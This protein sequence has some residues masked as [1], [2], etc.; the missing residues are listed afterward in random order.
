MLF[1]SNDGWFGQSIG[2][3]QHL[4][5]ARLRAVEQGL[6][7]VRAANTGISA[8]IDAYGRVVAFLRLGDRG[9]VDSRLPVALPEATLFARFGNWILLLL[10]VGVG[11]AGW[12]LGCRRDPMPQIIVY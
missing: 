9:V 3:Y 11:G 7:L 6:P 8:V 2:P 4:A 1:R 5:M 10:L 12:R